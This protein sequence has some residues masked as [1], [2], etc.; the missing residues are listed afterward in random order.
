[1]STAIKAALATGHAPR[2]AL[3]SPVVKALIT[4]ATDEDYAAGYR[5]RAAAEFAATLADLEFDDA[6]IE[7]MVARRYG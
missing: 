2:K 3:D 4:G 7:R 1:M 5:S 6:T